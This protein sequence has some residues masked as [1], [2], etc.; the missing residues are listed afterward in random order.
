MGADPGCVMAW[1]GLQCEK[2]TKTN[3]ATQ[4][5]NNSQS[6]NAEEMLSR[7]ETFIEKNKKAI[8]GV[9]AAVVLVIVAVVLYK[10]YYSGP[11]EE[12]AAVALY[13]AQEYFAAGDYEKTFYGDSTTYFGLAKVIG[14]YDGTKAANLAQAYAGLSL[15]H[16]GKFEEAVGYLEAYDGSDTY[17]ASAT[18]AALGNCRIN[19]GDIEAGAK[20]L[21][22]AAHKAD[23]QSL[24]PVWLRQAGVAYEK[25]GQKDK[26]LQCYTEI[27]DK[28]AGNPMVARDIDKYIEKVSE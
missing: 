9:I 11:R 18:L 4:K 3:M 26:A 20:L 2:Q 19:L 12:R 15:A 5:K 17:F 21:V 7:S 22:D 14:E 8:I 13:P 6:L 27:K 23:A 25:L 24:S 10:N 16:L 28:Y 1:R